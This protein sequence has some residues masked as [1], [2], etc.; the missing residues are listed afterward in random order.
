MSV[1]S[2]SARLRAAQ[3]D[4]ATNS[5]TLITTRGIKYSSFTTLTVSGIGNDGLA[6]TTKPPV[7]TRD[8]SNLGP[9]LTDLEGNPIISSPGA[10]SGYFSY[11]V[12]R[13]FQPTTS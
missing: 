12:V 6:A 11:E 7:R 4:P 1:S 2:G 5:V 8:Q 10:T 9:A 3:Y 13:G